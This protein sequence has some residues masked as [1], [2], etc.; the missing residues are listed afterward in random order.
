MYHY[1]FYDVSCYDGYVAMIL[2]DVNIVWLVLVRR[3]LS[4]M[5]R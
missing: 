3:A 1:D 2:F 5:R 4:M